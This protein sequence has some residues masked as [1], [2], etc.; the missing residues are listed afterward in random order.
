MRRVSLLHNYGCC[1]SLSRE[2]AA[3]LKVDFLSDF[4]ALQIARSVLVK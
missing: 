2:C 3:D 1:R 4:V